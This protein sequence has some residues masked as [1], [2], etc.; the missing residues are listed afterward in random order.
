MI[1]TEQKGKE[2][3]DQLF[4]NQPIAIVWFTPVFTISKLGEELLDDFKVGF[5]N[6]AACNVLGVD[7]ADALGISVMGTEIM[8]LI[9]RT[10]TIFM[11]NVHRS[12]KPANHLHSHIT[13]QNVTGGM[14]CNVL[15]LW[16]VC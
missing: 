10:H 16:M 15:N 6:E 12:C 3:F 11:S 8:D 5:C 14:L 13:A 1:L 9:S 4:S 2:L 7:V